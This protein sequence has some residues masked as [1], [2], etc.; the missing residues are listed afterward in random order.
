[1][2]VYLA[3]PINRK[4]RTRD[5]IAELD[6]AL[7]SIVAANQPMTVRQV[8]YQAVV[9]GLVP[10]DE[11]KGYDVVQR[12]LVKLRE[13]GEISYDW[14][15]DNARM[16]RGYDR[17]GGPEGFA[18]DVASLYRRNYWSTSPVAVEVW[19]EKDALASVLFPVVVEEWGLNLYVARGFASVTYLQNAADFIKHRRKP[20][21]VYVLS[22]FDPSG[23]G[24]AQKI[25]EELQ[26]RAAPVD[27]AVQRL[28]VTPEQ[29]TRW[30]LPTRDT[31][32][33]DS[34]AKKFM[35]KYGD[36]SVE[37]DAIPPPEL[38]ALVSTA[39]EQHAN[40]EEIARLKKAEELEREGFVG[41][42][43]GL[44]F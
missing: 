27:V 29:I 40:P 2:E 43:R 26:R 23:M 39:I 16:V 4:R 24:L 41:V 12:R 18:R 30:K 35:E 28:A 21:F 34:R 9:R 38:R 19:I 44:K 1:M 22:D 15:T 42:M 3:S 8:F 25:G 20:T 11:G 7:V 10:K 36:Q 5:E 13:S 6:R 17:W 37:L 33:T 31:K 32:K 14:I